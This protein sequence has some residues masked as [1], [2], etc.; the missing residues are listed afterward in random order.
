MMSRIEAREHLDAIRGQGIAFGGYE[1]ADRKAMIDALHAAE[2]GEREDAQA[3]PK[4]PTFDQ[5]AAMGI[6]VEFVDPPSEPSQEA[7]SNG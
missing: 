6:H 1:Q 4:R 5:I 7:L 2:R 3:K